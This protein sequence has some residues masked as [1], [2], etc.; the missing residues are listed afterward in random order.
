MDSF[1]AVLVSS[2]S[3]E[4]FNTFITSSVAPSSKASLAS[5]TIPVPSAYKSASAFK[6]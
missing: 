2:D 5:I 6:P 3:K 1:I 4:T